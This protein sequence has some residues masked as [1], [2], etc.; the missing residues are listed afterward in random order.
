MIRQQVGD[1]IVEIISRDELSLQ[2]EI[3]E[4]NT[5]AGIVRLYDKDGR[6]IDEHWLTVSKSKVFGF[7]QLELVYIPSGIHFT[8]QEA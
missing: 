6:I 8:E 7:N 3:Q 1:T 4:P 2:A 5:N